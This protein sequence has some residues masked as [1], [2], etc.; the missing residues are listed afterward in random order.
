MFE[1]LTGWSRRVILPQT[2]SAH[3]GFGAE[4]WKSDPMHYEGCAVCEEGSGTCD[5]PPEVTALLAP[6]QARITF[7][8]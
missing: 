8:G 7:E 3:L 1:R 5:T 4:Y 2:A 6:R